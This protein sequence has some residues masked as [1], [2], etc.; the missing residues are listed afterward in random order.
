MK[1]FILF[2][3]LLS[4]FF[5]TAQAFTLSN[6]SYVSIITCGPGIELFEAYGHTAIRVRDPLQRVDIVFNYGIFDFDDPNFYLN[7]AKGHL[8]Y[9]IDAENFDDFIAY[10][11]YFGRSVKEQ[12]LRL[13]SMQKMTVLS[14]LQNNMLPENQYYFYDYFYNNCA[15]KILDVVLLNAGDRLTLANADLS[16][17]KSFR[18]L[19][20]EYHQN[21]AWGDLGIDICLGLPCDKIATIK[22]TAF[23]P[24]Y[25]FNLLQN[26]KIG[27]DSLVEKTV[28][29]LPETDLMHKNLPHPNVVFGIFVSMLFLIN[30]YRF[31]KAKTWFW[32]DYL[33][34][35][36]LGMVGCLLFFLWFF[37]DHKAS[38]VNLNLL[39]LNPFLLVYSLTTVFLSLKLKNLLNKVFSI[40]Y[41]LILLVLPFIP[42]DVPDIAFYFAGWCLSV[43]L[44]RLFAK[45]PAKGANLLFP[46]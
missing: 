5:G 14:F 17:G 30:V 44:L 46:K 23:L 13:D 7:F 36:V 26:S 11:Q 31:L 4:G 2:I 10:Y 22:E 18:T 16:S 32:I 29:L 45:F 42:Q 6:Q 19:T 1:R 34:F 43:F 39:W 20:D 15:T 40:Y 9:R 24:E 3:L 35:F 41:L 8:R 21:Q 28:E 12:I 33:L 25:L 37:T 38:A 27:D